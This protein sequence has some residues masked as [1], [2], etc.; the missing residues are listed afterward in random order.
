M[1]VVSSSASV[2]KGLRIHLSFTACGH[3]FRKLT[4]CQSVCQC[5]Q[6]ST[7]A[8]AVRDVPFS[9]SLSARP[10]HV[11]RTTHDSKLLVRVELPAGWPDARCHAVEGYAQRGVIIPF[12]AER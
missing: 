11:T 2:V 5:V 8:P 4:V 7:L 1:A 9:P 3:H 12:R 6:L 10:Y